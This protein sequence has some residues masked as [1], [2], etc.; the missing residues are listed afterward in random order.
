MRL[1]FCQHLFSIIFFEAWAARFTGPP[2]KAQNANLPVFSVISGKIGSFK[3]SRRGH[4]QPLGR[5]IPWFQPGAFKRFAKMLVINEL[6]KLG[7]KRQGVK[8]E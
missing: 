2:R 8:S 6:R 5:V 1:V 7:A 3:R 4:Y